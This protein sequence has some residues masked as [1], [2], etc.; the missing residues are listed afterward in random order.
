MPPLGSDEIAQWIAAIGQGMYSPQAGPQPNE[1]VQPPAVAPPPAVQPAGVPQGGGSMQPVPPYQSSWGRTSAVPYNKQ[2]MAADVV[3]SVMNAWQAHKQNEKAKQAQT[4]QSAFQLI[5]MGYPAEMILNNPKVF[6]AIEKTLNI[7]LPKDEGGKVVAPPQQFG[8]QATQAQAGHLQGR[9]GPAQVER[10]TDL[11]LLPGREKQ[12]EAQMR[13][14]YAL[15]EQSLRSS[16]EFGKSKMGL[17]EAMPKLGPA[18]VD[19]IASYLFGAKKSLDPATTKTLEN[20]PDK[21]EQELQKKY[22]DVLKEAFP[23]MLDDPASLTIVSSLAA[24]GKPL[25]T[26]IGESGQRAIDLVPRV[27]ARDAEGKIL[28]DANG[29]EILKPQNMSAMMIGVDYL[30]KELDAKVKELRPAQ[31]QAETANTQ[32]QMQE[33]GQDIAMKNLLLTSKMEVNGQSLPVY[34][35]K[36]TTEV[37]EA[38]QR[39]E[40]MR[41]DM[42]NLD[43]MIQAIKSGRLDE[44]SQ[45]AM[46]TQ[47]AQYLG[48]STTGSSSGFWA[49]LHSMTGWNW[50]TPKDITLTPNISEKDKATYDKLVKPAAAPANKSGGAVYRKP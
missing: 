8:Q 29:K 36:I 43:V 30:N 6:K 10:M 12:V 1:N 24:Q 44:A 16:A 42:P 34:L 21:H 32:Q 45:Q 22:M 18:G 39:Y 40:K 5:Q 9:V 13:G 2:N 50:T 31:I 26:V 27:P 19:D 20:L 49:W 41:K 47:M 7:E 38:Q 3:G 37:Q 14:Q 33:R 23:Q 46:V 28:K 4:A 25:S 17:F 48:Y 15:A 11:G 35:A